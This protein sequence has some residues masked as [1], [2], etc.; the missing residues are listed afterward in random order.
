GRQKVVPAPGNG[1]D[2]LK[3]HD[4]VSI[5]Y[6]GWLYDDDASDKKGKQF[7]SPAGRGDLIT[8]VGIGRVIRG[9]LGSIT[10]FHKIFT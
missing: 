6:T 8:P 10:T 7:D 4:K 3:K 1:S 2:V 5:E 9:W